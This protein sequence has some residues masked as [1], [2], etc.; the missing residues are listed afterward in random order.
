M[1]GKK[2]ETET[3]SKKKKQSSGPK[4][5][6]RREKYKGFV[7]GQTVENRIKKVR[8]LLKSCGP[9]GTAI[10]IMSCP[11]PLLWKGCKGKNVQIDAQHKTGWR[12]RLDAEFLHIIEKNGGKMGRL[13]S[14]C[15][16]V[17]DDP[18]LLEMMKKHLKA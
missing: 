9:R 5:V 8:R 4:G 12:P 3:K 13:A 17:V 14:E 15:L 2:D 11:D 18:C 6:K 10:A 16:R 1:P 7:R